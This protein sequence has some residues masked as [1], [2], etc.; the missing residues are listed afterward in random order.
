MFFAMQD[1]RARTE[2]LARLAVLE[3]TKSRAAARR[4]RIAGPGRTRQRPARRLRRLAR[5]VLSILI[6]TARV[7]PAHAM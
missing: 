5:R 6:R 7:R 4:A 3:L 1:T 2:A